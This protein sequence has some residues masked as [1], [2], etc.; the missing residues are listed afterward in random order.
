MTGKQKL[1]KEDEQLIV[2]LWIERELISHDM[3][4]LQKR[5]T[6]LRQQMNDLQ[7]KRSHLSKLA[8]ARKFDVA[9]TTVY[10]VINRKSVYIHNEVIKRTR[11]ENPKT[12]N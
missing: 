12:K 4:F 2:E 6:T 9:N 5:I 3:M 10:G 7:R 1:T 11:N 8:I